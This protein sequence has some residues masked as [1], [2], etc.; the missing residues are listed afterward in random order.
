MI[1]ASPRFESMSA[2]DAATNCARH[3]PIQACRCTL[4]WIGRKRW[5]SG[6]HPAGVGWQTNGQRR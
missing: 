4:E 5:H 1:C 6:T 3:A 2:S